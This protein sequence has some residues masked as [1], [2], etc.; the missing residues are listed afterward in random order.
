M[1]VVVGTAILNC[2][3]LAPLH[4]EAAALIVSLNA[5]V[6]AFAGI[7]YWMISARPRRRPEPFVLVTVAAVDAASVAVG[8]ARPEFGI[9]ISSYLLLLPPV[10]ALV[11]LWPT[12]IHVIWLT[13]H[14]VVVVGYAALAPEAAFAGGSRGDIFTLLAVVS[15]VSLL[16]H[17]AGL[18]ARV[19][20]FVQIERI[21]ALNRQARRDEARLD[22]LNGILEQATRTDELTGLKNRLS[23]NLDLGIIRGRIA[24]HHE[25]YGVL[26]LDL[27]RFK[28]INDQLGH[29]AG[30]RVLRS[31][32]GALADAVRAGD[33]VYRYGGEEFV[34]LTKV[35]GPDEA[36][37]A[38]HRLRAAVAA[39]RI[40]HPGN[41][42]HD[43]VTL[44]VGVATVGQEDLT[45]DEEEWFARADAALYRAKA[46][47]RN[48]VESALIRSGPGTEQASA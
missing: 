14:G 1:A 15:V 37:F 35:T 21:R 30:D 36:S 27:D 32:A 18:R 40:P 24:R 16:G 25:R 7:A 22:R 20:S 8:V 10:V 34:V 4:P 48:A 31:V 38:A 39:L 45:T 5:V 3:W 9:L 12:R 33:G 47:G 6:A 41:P 19:E 43:R 23:L 44:S 17:V 46:S 42:P 13:F 28:A 11:V 29:V 2:L 26:V